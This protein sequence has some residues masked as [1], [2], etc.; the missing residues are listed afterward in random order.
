MVDIKNIRIKKRT[1]QFGVKKRYSSELKYKKVQKTPMQKIQEAIAAWKKPKSKIVLEDEDEEKK[2]TMALEQ[3][4]KKK[5]K[6]PLVSPKLLMKAGG[7]LVLFILFMITAV[8]FFQSS[9]YSQE[10]VLNP[11]SIQSLSVNVDGYDLLTASSEEQPRY[12]YHTAFVRLSLEGKGTGEIPVQLEAHNTVVPSSVY[13]LRSYRYQAET[14]SEFINTLKT[15][16]ST[17]GIPVNEIGM[18][19][20]SS[21]PSQSLVIVPSGYIPEQML[22]GQDTKLTGL[23]ARG[24]T[25][26]YIGQP[27][28]RMYGVQGAVVSANPA[29]L[30]PMRVSFDEVT[31]ISSTTGFN[32]KSPL[33]SISGA[34]LIWGS[35]SALSYEKGYLVALPQTLDGGWENGKDAA[36]DVY[37]L[38]VQ[39]PWL[40]PIGTASENVTVG[41]NATFV[42]L[43]TSTFEGNNKYVRVYGFN[44]ETRIGFSK[45]LYIQKSTNGELYTQGH[46]IKPAG[47]GS[48]QMDIMAELN[49]PGGEERIFFTVTQL[50]EEVDREPIATTKVPLNSRP[51]FP[52][53]F[54]LSSGNYILN[55]VDSDGK[56]YARS[57]LRVGTLEIVQGRHITGSDIY[58]FSFYLDGQIIPVTGSV[59]VNGNTANRMDFE[60]VREVEIEAAKLLGGPLT[61]NEDHTFIFELGE[62]EFT[63]T[64]RKTAATSIFENPLMM[65]AVL[66]GVLA[67]GIGFLFARKGVTMYGLDIPDFPP[68]ST[69]KIP[70]K[71][72]KLI[73]IFQ[74]INE[75]YKWKATPL[76]LSEVKSGFRGILHEGKPIFISDYNLEYL[77][78]RLMGMGLIKK[79]LKYYG[80]TSWEEETGSTVRHL[81][82]FRKL[83]DICI[84]NAVPFTPLG[85]SKNY[86]SKITIIGQDIYVHLY[87]DAGRI[88]PNAL[89]SIKNGLNIILFEEEAEKSEFYEYLSS[90][91]TGGTT[92]KLEVQAGSV[93]LKTWKEFEEMVK[94]MKV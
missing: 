48:T 12:P 15:N 68:Q 53:E 3:S 80:L 17:W 56:A 38:I 41:E 78:L 70:M 91:Y 8:L 4:T 62:F 71:K 50:L 88:I 10:I 64:V 44:E 27:F 77:L 90:G 76:T 45:V 58:K 30:D 81:A 2:T 63:E 14:Y 79:E 5:E 43:F 7:A 66:I 55:V 23:L 33:Y 51:T 86:D 25:V 22:T 89:A 73:A 36:E 37:D 57:Y 87:D 28:F 46:D 29:A 59:Y 65:G 18:E 11:V 93:L 61:A 19:E 82:F 69:T 1:Y 20:L 60:N 31:S 24:I 34:T 85:K 72:E 47:L 67:L 40:T 52:Y 26:L 75:R 42:E 9:V 39:M 54:V 49:E 32:L 21:L 92:L 13:I 35:V 83:R 6:K 74:K 84:N 94:E 16:L